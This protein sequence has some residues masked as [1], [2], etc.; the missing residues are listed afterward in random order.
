MQGVATVLCGDSSAG[1]TGLAYTEMYRVSEY[2]ADLDFLDNHN[3]ASSEAQ[4]AF[5]TNT[6]DALFFGD[7]TPIARYCV[8]HVDP[9]AVG[10]ITDRVGLLCPGWQPGEGRGRGRGEYRLGQGVP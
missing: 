6:N 4:A 2:T 10:V 3:S 9:A 7:L 5:V 1:C 8:V